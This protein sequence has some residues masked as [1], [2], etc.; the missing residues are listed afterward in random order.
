MSNL[1]AIKSNNTYRSNNYDSI[2]YYYSCF[3]QILIDNEATKESLMHFSSVASE[4]KPDPRNRNAA[5][6]G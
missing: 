5:D 2:E 4:H 6:M 1:L 3:Y